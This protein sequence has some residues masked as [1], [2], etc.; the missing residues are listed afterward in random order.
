MQAALY[1]LTGQLV[2][3]VVPAQRLARGAHAVALGNPPAGFYLV[4]LQVDDQ[5]TSRKVVME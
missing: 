1:N 2:R 4:K 3:V 5:V